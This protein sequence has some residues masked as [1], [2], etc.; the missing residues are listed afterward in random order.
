VQRLIEIWRQLPRPLQQPIVWW[1]QKNRPLYRRLLFRHTD[2]RDRVNGRSAGMP[3]AELRYR[4]SSAP[5]LERFVSIG[6]A[7]CADLRSAL[8]TVS[9]EL[10]SFEK[11]L[12]F[13][14]GCGRTLMR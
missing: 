12:D 8:S 4:V 5:D 7:C 1:V 14:C 10:S 6:E 13:G 9:R 2:A 3:P 11:I